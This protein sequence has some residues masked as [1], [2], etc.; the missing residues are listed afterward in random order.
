MLEY[1][2][3]PTNPD[4]AQAGPTV[5]KTSSHV[6][7]RIVFAGNLEIPSQTEGNHRGARKVPQN[8]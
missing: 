7:S 6:A 5:K 4:V 1:D 2:L 8:S 3:L